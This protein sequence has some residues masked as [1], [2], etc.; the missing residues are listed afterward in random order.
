MNAKR[1]TVQ[2]HNQKPFFTDEIKIK[3]PLVPNPETSKHHIGMKNSI[4]KAKGEKRERGETWKRN[5][6]KEIAN[7]ETSKHDMGM[8]NSIEEHNNKK[9]KQ[10]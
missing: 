8:R 9:W 1:T 2:Y 5:K 4:E 3:L 10:S 7:P 6:Q